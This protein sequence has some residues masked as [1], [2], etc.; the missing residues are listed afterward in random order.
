[1]GGRRSR[2]RGKYGEYWVRDRLKSLVPGSSCYRIPISGCKN[3]P[4]DLLWDLPGN[5]VLVEVKTRGNGK[6]MKKYFNLFCS[7][8]KKVSEKTKQP[9]S[10]FPVM[11]TFSNT[12]ILYVPPRFKTLKG[13]ITCN[14]KNPFTLSKLA[15]KWYHSAKKKA[16][17]Y[18]SGCTPALVMKCLTPKEENKKDKN[19]KGAI[20]CIFPPSV[21]NIIKKLVTSSCCQ[22]KILCKLAKEEFPEIGKKLKTFSLFVK[23]P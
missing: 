5:K 15:E 19:L 18:G 8:F 4:G 22:K 7:L 10:T 23:K 16:E 6:G 12:A 3:F 14:V 17:S 2:Q 1:L 9:L 21:G 13:L 11:L 20:I